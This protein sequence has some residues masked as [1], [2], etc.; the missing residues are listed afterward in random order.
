MVLVRCEPTKLSP[1]VNLNCWS[2]F[3]VSITL[4]TIPDPVDFGVNGWR[5]PGP[6]QGDLRLSG[7]SSGQGARGRARARDRRVP[8]DIRA[9]PLAPGSPTRLPHLEKPPYGLEGPLF[10]GSRV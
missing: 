1:A 9:D 6:Q 4:H 5:F 8:A 3:P 10:C 7:P 2:V